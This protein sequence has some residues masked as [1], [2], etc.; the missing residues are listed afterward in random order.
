MTSPT[1]LHLLARGRQN[2]FEQGF[3]VKSYLYDASFAW[4]YSTKMAWHLT[5]KNRA[6][7]G[8]YNDPYWRTSIQ[9]KSFC[10]F[11][12]IRPIGSP[13]HQNG[14]SWQMNDIFYAFKHHI[15]SAWPIFQDIIMSSIMTIIFLTN[16][17]QRF[18]VHNGFKW[19]L[20]Q[21]LLKTHQINLRLIFIMNNFAITMIN[22]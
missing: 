7:V 16:W 22:K 9:P 5:Q 8:Q 21:N 18:R 20:Q 3:F 11:Q 10:Q 6:W 1:L 14:G 2:L 13:V 19:F 12:W 15:S 4:N 17:L